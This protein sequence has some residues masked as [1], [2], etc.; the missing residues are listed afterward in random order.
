MGDDKKCVIFRC[1]SEFEKDY[2]EGLNKETYQSQMADPNLSEA[3]KKKLK[4]IC[5]IF[6]VDSINSMR[7]Y[8][9][10][11]CFSFWIETT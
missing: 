4:V 11:T 3:E 9:Y 1:Q 10:V 8:R 6:V 7:K 2:M 5:T